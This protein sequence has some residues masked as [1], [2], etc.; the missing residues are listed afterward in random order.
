VG[1]RKQLVE[2]INSGFVP[3]I[4]K[5]D[6]FVDYYCMY[7]DDGSLV[8]VSVYRNARGAED[9]VRAAAQWVAQN[10]AENLPEKPEVIEGE[11]FAHRAVEKQKA[12]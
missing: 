10:I 2:R 7:A 1:D 8:S 4:A 11:V 9:S 12:A 6:G 3:L 5:I